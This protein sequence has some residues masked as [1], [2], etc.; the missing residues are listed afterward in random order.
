MCDRWA[1]AQRTR[2]QDGG[3]IL[4]HVDDGDCCME[5]RNDVTPTKNALTLLDCGLNGPCLVFSAAC[6]APSSPSCLPDRNKKCRHQHRHRAE[7]ATQHPGEGLSL[8]CTGVSFSLST[9]LHAHRGSK[10]EEVGLRL[11]WAAMII[12][13]HNHHTHT[14]THTHTLLGPTPPLS[15]RG[16]EGAAS[17]L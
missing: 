14:H 10:G 2:P 17:P 11:G 4:T 3:P 1:P 7:Q 15:T 16:L 8:A 5:G 9:P 13:H 6:Q 12:H